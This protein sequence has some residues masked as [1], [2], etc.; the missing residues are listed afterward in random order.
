MTEYIIGFAIGVFITTLCAS[1]NCL[2]GDWTPEKIK[3][4][5]EKLS[6]IMEEYHTNN[7]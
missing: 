7:Y 3:K 4:L 6:D 2:V 1:Y 5:R